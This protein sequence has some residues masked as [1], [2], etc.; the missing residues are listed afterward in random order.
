MEDSD[1]GTNFVGAEKELRNLAK[2]INDRM[3][4]EATSEFQIEWH[5]NPPSAPHFGGLWERQIQTIKKGLR[6]MMEDWKQR[7]PSPETLTATLLQIEFILKSR[8]LT[9]IPVL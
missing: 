7:K 8:P 2:E 1:N 6:Q 4:R 3:G 9:H 5:F